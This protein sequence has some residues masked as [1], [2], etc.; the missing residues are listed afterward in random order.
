MQHTEI[1]RLGAGLEIHIL[2]DTLDTNRQFTLFKVIV[3]P[4]AKVPAAHY[5]DQFDETIYGLKG[6]LTLTIDGK[7]I[8]LAPGECCFVPKG[9]V[10]R[11][12]NKTAE[13]VEL[14]AYAQSGVFGATYF[15]EL[16]EVINV[17]GPPDAGKLKAIMLSYGLVPV[18]G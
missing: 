8:E 1:I 7:T 18:S 6:L 3:E 14:L 15:R 13:S 9:A 16:A 4:A 17:G 5:H 12:E 2:L 10:H 11:F